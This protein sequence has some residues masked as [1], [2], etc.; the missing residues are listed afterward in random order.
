LI[1]L[2]NYFWLLPKEHA[3][4][5]TGKY[6]M[7]NH[8]R[9]NWLS[10]TSAWVLN[11]IRFKPNLPTRPRNQPLGGPTT[12]DQ[13]ALAA[14]EADLQIMSRQLVQLQE[15][16]RNR[17]ARELHD[18]FGQTLTALKINLDIA[19]RSLGQQSL[20]PQ[21]AAKLE[22]H[23]ME[24]HTLAVETMEMARNLS[25]QLHPAML[26]D[27]GL[28]P[29]LHWAIK[30]H[31]QRTDQQVHF[32]TNLTKVTLSPEVNLTLYRLITEALTNITRHAYA[33]QV[34]LD[35]FQRRGQLMLSI[36]DDGQG[37]DPTALSASP[38]RLGLLGMRE[39]VALHGGEFQL[40]SRP[41]QGTHLQIQLPWVG[42]T[43]GDAP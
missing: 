1:K 16:E 17:I 29:T 19:R 4:R 41:G 38:P 7:T 2:R 40:V 13:V 20:P 12:T 36:R 34:W 11:L 37:F 33:Q 6:A 42:I 3:T 10:L 9:R 21:A 26:D 24:A 22:H 14:R 18:S 5:T 23:L 43:A 39:R 31:Q 25:L 30:Q 27:L 8:I 35:L 32:Q 28:L 15:Q